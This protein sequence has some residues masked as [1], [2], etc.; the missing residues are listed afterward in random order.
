[1]RFYPIVALG[2]FDTWNIN[3]QS[4]W[5]WK[6]MKRGGLFVNLRLEGLESLVM[7]GRL[8]GFGAYAS[9]RLKL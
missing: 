7:P 5:N 6:P 9:A 4:S 8:N 2:G 3:L 1:M